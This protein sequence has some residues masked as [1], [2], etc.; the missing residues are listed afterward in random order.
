MWRPLNKAPPIAEMIP[1]DAR[2]NLDSNP[3]TG[4]C[5]CGQSFQSLDPAR[6]GLLLLMILSPSPATS[7]AIRNALICYDSASLRGQGG[8]PSGEIMLTTPRAILLGLGLIAV[9]IVAQPLTRNAFITPAHA[10]LN[11][12]DI[13]Y[14][15][16]TITVA[17]S[18][19]SAC[20]N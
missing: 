5:F 15:A 18:G 1:V 14:L 20:R 13:K 19:I 2:P 11:F 9:A 3:G 17:L 12:K 4:L 6:S 16:D 8:K 7:P 10:E